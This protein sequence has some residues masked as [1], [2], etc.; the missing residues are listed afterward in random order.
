MGHQLLQ[1]QP[2]LGRVLSLPQLRLW[3]IRRRGMQVLQRA[4][5]V[6]G[7]LSRWQQVLRRVAAKP[8]QGLAAE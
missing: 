3:R 5:K 1:R 4:A 8:G 6:I 2:L 7:V